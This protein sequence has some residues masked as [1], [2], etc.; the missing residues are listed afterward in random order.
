MKSTMKSYGC[1][2]ADGHPEP[3]GNMFTDLSAVRL[4]KWPYVVT[5]NMRPPAAVGLFC[6]SPGMISEVEHRLDMLSMFKR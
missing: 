5:W 3:A 1:M 2:S 6:S 4:F